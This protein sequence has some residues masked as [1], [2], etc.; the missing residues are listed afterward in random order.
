MKKYM[1]EGKTLLYCMYYEL[2]NVRNILNDYLSPSPS[3]SL[4]ISIR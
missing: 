4:T 3:L 2:R 1:R